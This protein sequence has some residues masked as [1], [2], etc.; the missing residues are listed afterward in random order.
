MV[1]HSEAVRT[2]KRAQKES[3]IFKELSKLFHEIIMDDSRFQTL[4]INRV[5]LSN[6][7]SMCT[8]F[9]YTADGPEAYKELLQTLILYKPSMRKNLAQALDSRYVPDLRFE[10]DAKFEHQQRL[11][12]V[13]DKAAESIACSLKKPSDHE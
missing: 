6:D 10:Y 7:K 4:F 11:E 2:V 8:V 1:N 3:F 5:Q 13:L 9:F 12:A